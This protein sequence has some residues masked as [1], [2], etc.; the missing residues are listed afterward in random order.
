MLTGESYDDDECIKE[1][2]VDIEPIIKIYC[3]K[4]KKICFKYLEKCTKFVHNSNSY[5]IYKK[6]NGSIKVLPGLDYKGPEIT[7]HSCSTIETAMTMNFT[8]NTE[9]YFLY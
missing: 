9:F 2:F 6:T 1:L 8:D 3:D 5:I 4:T 7:K